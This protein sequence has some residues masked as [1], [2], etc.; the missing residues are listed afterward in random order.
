[1]ESFSQAQGSSLFAKAQRFGKLKE[2]GCRG[3]LKSGTG[4]QVIYG[5]QVTVIKNELE[6]ALGL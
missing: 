3:V 4:V 2:S 1:M 5:P 6:E